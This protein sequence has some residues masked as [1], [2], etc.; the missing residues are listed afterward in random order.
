M[1][2]SLRIGLGGVSLDFITL[3]L[4]SERWGGGCLALNLG[5]SVPR[6]SARQKESVNPN[7]FKTKRK[8]ICDLNAVLCSGDKTK[9]IK[10]TERVK[11][12]K[13]RPH[14]KNPLR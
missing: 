13:Q 12:A 7:V 4:Y 2:M 9:T 6:F 8:G 11:P 10:Q 3:I 5:S 1:Q 14:T